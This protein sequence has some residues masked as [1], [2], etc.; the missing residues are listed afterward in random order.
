MRGAAQPVSRLWSACYLQPCTSRRVTAPEG[1]KEE[2]CA[3][4]SPPTLFLH[5][6]FLLSSQIA[7]QPAI[8]LKISPP[9]SIS[10]IH[11]KN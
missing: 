1:T 5:I 8:P 4:F 3:R 6:V 7:L 9:S 2:G 11:L 10:L